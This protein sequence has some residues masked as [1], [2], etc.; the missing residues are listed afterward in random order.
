[1]AKT[2]IEL[3]ATF[4]PRERQLFEYLKVGFSRA[5]ADLKNLSHNPH[6]QDYRERM[7]RIDDR[8]SNYAFTAREL[9]FDFNYDRNFVVG[10][11]LWK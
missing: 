9:G 5:V 11:T 7:T 3:L 8:I 2:A 6:A 1:M 10:I 4:T